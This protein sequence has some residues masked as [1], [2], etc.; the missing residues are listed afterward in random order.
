MADAVDRVFA[1]HADFVARIEKLRGADPATRDQMTASP[2]HA[3][4]ER[5]HGAAGGRMMARISAA[6]PCLDKSPRLR[7]ALA[8]LGKRP[9]P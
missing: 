5:T 7:A 9:P 8:R 2:A 4:F 3:E 6:D 1:D